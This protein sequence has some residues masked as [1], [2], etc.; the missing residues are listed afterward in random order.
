MKKRKDDPG[1]T[2]EQQRV[3][4]P[5]EMK[6]FLKMD[7]GSQLAGLVERFATQ[8]DFGK[9]DEVVEYMVGEQL[10]IA[11]KIMPTLMDPALYKDSPTIIIEVTKKGEEPFTMQAPKRLELARSP[12]DAL[13]QAMILCLL[14]SAPVRALLRI[15]GYSYTF[16]EIKPKSSL[17][18]Q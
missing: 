4:T 13:A 2:G 10:E 14:L 11:E 15:H 16:K 18:L 7:I 9:L 5:E 1:E 8:F 6:Q 12:S 17:I 3:P